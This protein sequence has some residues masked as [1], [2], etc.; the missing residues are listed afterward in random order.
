[1]RSYQTPKASSPLSCFYE[2][3]VGQENGRT[4]HCHPIGLL[5]EITLMMGQG[6]GEMAKRHT[7]TKCGCNS[8]IFIR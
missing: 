7:T 4:M 1:V 6:G 3:M 8:L 2:V 5:D